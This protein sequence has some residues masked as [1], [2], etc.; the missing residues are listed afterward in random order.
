MKKI[1]TILLLTNSFNSL[2]MEQQS[3]LDPA[4]TGFLIAQHIEE[5]AIPMQKSQKVPLDDVEWPP[6]IAG[7]LLPPFLLQPLIPSAVIKAVRITKSQKPK[8]S[9]AGKQA[10]KLKTKGLHI[11]TWAGCGTKFT[12]ERNRTKH[13][14]REHLGI[15]N[16]KC[17]HCSRG[18]YD[19][20]DCSKHSK[21][22]HGIANVIKSYH[23]PT[24]EP[25]QLK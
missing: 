10:G 20:S 8:P 2:A 6:E 12:K 9:R 3:I 1:L 15:T 19:K 24:I 11:C 17:G 25:E 4:T 16:Y 14:K 5:F 22:R 18:F 7:P 21:N 23:K 13:I